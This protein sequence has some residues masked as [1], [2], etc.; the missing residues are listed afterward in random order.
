MQSARLLLAQGGYLDT[1]AVLLQQAAEKY[2][3]GYLLA[4]GW[5]LRRIHD[6]EALVNDAIDYDKEFERFLDLARVLSGFYLKDRYPPA[7][8]SMYNRDEIAGIGTLFQWRT[9]FFPT[10]HGSAAT[11]A[12][13]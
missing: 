10:Q 4:Q 9:A 7:P 3:K 12:S 1:I 8:S 5:K 11:L 6:L 13:L 2:L